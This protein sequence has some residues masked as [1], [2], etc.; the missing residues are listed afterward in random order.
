MKQKLHSKLKSIVGEMIGTDNTINISLVI[1]DNHEHG[2]YATN[3][4]MQLTKVLRSNPKIIAENIIKMV[5]SDKS[6]EG[7][8]AEIAGPG[9]INFR[10]PKSYFHDTVT[11]ILSDTNNFFGNNLGKGK[12][13]IVE[14]VSANPTGPLHIGHGRGAAYGD[15][16]ARILACSGYEVYKEY[17]VNDAGNQMYNLGL[18]VYARLMEQEGKE[19]P[20]PESG[21]HGD[22]IKE[23]A[24]NVKS[25]NPKI[26]ELDE[27]EAVAICLDIAVKTISNS[28]DNDLR[29]FDVVFDSWFSEKSLY[30]SGAVEKALDKLDK[31]G[32]L[33]EKDGALWFA[34][35]KNGDDKDR[36]LRKSTGEYTYF[37]PDIAYHEDKYMRGFDRLIDVLGA[38]HHGYVKRMNCAINALGHDESSFEAMLIQMVNLVKDGEKLSMSTRSGTFIELSW[39]IDEVGKDAARFFY[40]MRGHESQFDFDINLAK[41]KSSDNPVYYIQYAHARVF[42]LIANAKDKGH[43]YKRG[44]GLEKLIQTSEMEIIKC[45]MKLQNIIELSSKHLEPHRIAH[46][47]QE[48]AALFHNYYYANKIIILNDSETT[49][50]RLT[51]AE[52][53]AC[54]IRFG[55]SLLGV[56]APE[57]M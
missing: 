9:F 52:S 49:N 3:I 11:D 47:L 39:L 12:R 34:S 7:I 53:V 45:M 18:S 46:Q 14:F 5:E 2:D 36:V 4:A 24:E 37:T 42:S 32:S 44:E 57:R 22:Y 41:S 13:V 21:Y 29:N 55:L 30:T 25:S 28:I 48:L 19:Y 54:A 40:N 16:I 33:Y 23:I 1:P 6:L 10:L 35:E 56:S 20:F 26:L 17:Y 27:K 31:N 51:L 43:E 8:T 50:A 38:D 15:S